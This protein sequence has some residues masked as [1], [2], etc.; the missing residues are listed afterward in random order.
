V[1]AFDAFVNGRKHCRAGVGEVGTLHACLAW[2]AWPKRKRRG[3]VEDASRTVSLQLEGRAEASY[4]SWPR[5][6]LE[7]GDQVRLIVVDAQQVDP[8]SHE[9]FDS[10][11]DNKWERRLYLSLKRKYDRAS[12]RHRR[13][14]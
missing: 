5:V 8:P 13:R 11:F 3:K 1:I 9:R 10:D 14:R 7:V 2:V 4:R 6:Q 12:R